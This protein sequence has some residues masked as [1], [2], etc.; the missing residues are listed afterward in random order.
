MKSLVKRNDLLPGFDF[1]GDDFFSNVVRDWLAR[2]LFGAEDSAKIDIL[3]HDD[4]IEVQAEVPGFKKE[5]I[6]VKYEG[7]WLT[8]SGEVKKESKGN[9]T[10][11]LHREI[12]SRSFTRRFYL[13]DSFVTDKIDAEFKDGVLNVT[14]P[15][16]EREKFRRI[17]VK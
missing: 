11:Y 17:D 8:I 13:G 3:E 7:G 4:K 9:E 16:S 2:P 15:K 6:E 1:D 10:K 14:L 12:G 5:D